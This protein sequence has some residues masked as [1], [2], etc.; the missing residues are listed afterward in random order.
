LPVK[1]PRAASPQQAAKVL[2]GGGVVALV[3]H[4]DVLVE[5][6]APLA[7]EEAAQVGL[8]PRPHQLHVGLRAAEDAAPIEQGAVE[9]PV[10]GHLDGQAADVEGARPLGLEPAVAH[11]GALTHHQLGDGVGVA[12]AL[13]LAFKQLDHADIT[14][15][16]RQDEQAGVVRDGPRG[17]AP[18]ELDGRFDAGAGGD[19]QQERL[20]VGEVLG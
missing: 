2:G 9:P 13:A 18:L 11:A 7:S 1:T 6:A 19:V 4:G 14:A 15:F 10:A 12:G 5:V 3:G 8:G 20:A 17:H 16:F